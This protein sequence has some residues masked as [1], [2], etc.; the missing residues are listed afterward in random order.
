MAS[1]KAAGQANLV[2]FEQTK[3]VPGYL[4]TLG[5]DQ[6]CLAATLERSIFLA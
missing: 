3:T 6:L 4:P 1:M 5:S 2:G